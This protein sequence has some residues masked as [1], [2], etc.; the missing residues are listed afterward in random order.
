[1]L[2]WFNNIK[3]SEEYAGVKFKTIFLEKKQIVN[4]KIPELI[5]WCNKLA[6]LGLS[7]FYGT[8]SAGNLSFRTDSGFIITAA[9]TYLDR[10]T[11]EDFVEV[12]DC[13]PE[14]MEIAVKG[15]REPSSESCIHSIIY[16]MHPDIKAIFHAHSKELLASDLPTTNVEHPYGS[17]ELAKV[18]EELAKTYNLFNLRNHGFIS[19]GKSMEDAGKQVLTLLDSKQLT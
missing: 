7:P 8:G 18:A 6:E 9:K 19:L 2:Y 3:M 10:V 12:L 11:E 15:F 4:K 17:L 5:K 1:M 14:N 16:K 13:I